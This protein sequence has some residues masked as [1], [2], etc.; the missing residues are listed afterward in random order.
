VKAEVTAEET[1]ALSLGSISA[2]MRFVSIGDDWIGSRSAS[3]AW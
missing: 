1:A 3:G 2:Y